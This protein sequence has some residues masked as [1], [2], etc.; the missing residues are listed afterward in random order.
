[1]APAL[2]RNWWGGGGAR[3]RELRVSPGPR[4]AGG[5]GGGRGSGAAVAA[6]GGQSRGAALWCRACGRGLRRALLGKRGVEN[7]RSL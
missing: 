4:G 3:G 2:Q 7:T 5:V 6:A 1:M